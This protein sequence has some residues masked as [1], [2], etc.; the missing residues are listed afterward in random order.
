MKIRRTKAEIKAGLTVDQKKSGLTLESFLQKQKEQSKEEKKRKKL[1]KNSSSKRKQRAPNHNYVT[2]K[3]V[4]RNDFDGP[5]KYVYKTETKVVEKEVKIPVIKE[6]R[7]LNGTKSSEK[8]VQEIMTIELEKCS[9]EWKNVTMDNTFKVTDLNKYGK[10]GWKF[11]FIYDP[12]VSFPKS[13]KPD[14]IVFQ[15]PKTWGK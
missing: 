14:E 9:W 13:T 1:L 12:K 3:E 10:K 4:I 7:I 11:C 5:T 8:T 2:T 15:R 6:V